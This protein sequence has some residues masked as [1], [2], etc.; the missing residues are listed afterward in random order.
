[1]I[2]QSIQSNHAIS[3]P[4]NPY[5]NKISSNSNSV[6]TKQKQPDYD[7]YIPENKPNFDEKA[8]TGSSTKDK[9]SMH[10]NCSENNEPL[11][12]MTVE[13][14]NDEFPEERAV[15]NEND[16]SPEERTVENED[17]NKD[18]V[19]KCIANT[20]RVDKEIQKLKEKKKQIKNELH[21]NIPIERRKEL[22]QRLRR[23]TQ[24]LQ[25]KDNDFYRQQHA[26]FSSC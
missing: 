2:I 6:P 20:N 22:E 8:V 4:K 15:E 10:C 7:E 19:K 23:I 17:S 24:E 3:I 18:G 16:E 1:M 13:N 9:P 12:E 21:S 14:E 26:N 5:E 25:Q 11:E